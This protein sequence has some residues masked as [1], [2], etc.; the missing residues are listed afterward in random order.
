ML[1]FPAPWL[2]TVAPGAQTLTTGVFHVLGLSK[3]N[4][5]VGV[6]PAPSA[7]AVAIP[8]ID[9]I[10]VIIIASASTILKIRLTMPCFL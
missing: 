10:I 3:Y 4:R 5:I 7:Y 9:G 2:T 8:P 1:A 6:A